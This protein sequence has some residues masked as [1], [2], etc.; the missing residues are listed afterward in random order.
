MSVSVYFTHSNFV[1]KVD[2]CVVLKSI[3]YFAWHL[4]SNTDIRSELLLTKISSLTHQLIFEISVQNFVSLS[5]SLIQQRWKVV[6]TE[7]ERRVCPKVCFLCS[8]FPLCYVPFVTK[9]LFGRNRCYN[10]HWKITEKFKSEIL[11]KWTHVHNL[12]CTSFFSKFTP[13]F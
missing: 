11:T 7:S 9:R 5:A 2:S 3:V 6:P 4:S 10:L 1:Q 12:S 13:R 8:P